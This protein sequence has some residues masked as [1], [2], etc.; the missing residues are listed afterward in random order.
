M[1]VL[2]HTKIDQHLCFV[3]Y[4]TL[5][6]LIKFCWWSQAVRYQGVTSLLFSMSPLNL[7][8]S[9]NTSVITVYVYTYIT[10]AHLSQNTLPTMFEALD[11]HSSDTWS[12]F[13]R[14]ANCEKDFPSSVQKR[15]T[16]FQQVSVH[17]QYVTF[18][19]DTA[20]HLQHAV[21]LL[22]NSRKSCL[23]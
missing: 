10:N 16:Q 5:Q 22:Y 23:Y 13:V 9:N 8:A 6:V 4:E 12:K 20:I 18:I 11:L 15:I 17:V 1:C 14:S 7:C 3:T 21:Q 2:Q 19:A